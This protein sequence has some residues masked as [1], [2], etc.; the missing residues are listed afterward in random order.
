MTNEKNTARA[1]DPN[2][3]ERQ[4]LDP[5]IAKTEAEWWA[6]R[7][8]E[9]LERE[10]DKWREASRVK[11]LEAIEWAGKHQLLDEHCNALQADNARLL[12][13]LENCRLLA[14]RS[15]KE[16]WGLLIL[17]FCAEG[18]VIGSATRDNSDHHGPDW[19]ER[20]GEYPDDLGKFVAGRCAETSEEMKEQE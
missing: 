3:L 20:D 18:G 16:S 2:D 9:E 8:I 5:N 7:R 12:E 17:R 4:I 19:T 15:R 10:V 11:H 1:T 14:A 6:K 13:A